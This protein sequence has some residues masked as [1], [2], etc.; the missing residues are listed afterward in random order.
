MTSALRIDRLTLSNFRCFEKFTVDLH[1][2][3]TVLVAENGQGKTA[4]LEAIRIALGLFVDTIA[5]TRQARVFSLSDVRTVRD[6]GDK[7]R[8]VF[9][10]EF[11]AEGDFDG[12]SIHW[13][14]ALNHSAV[15]PRTTTRKAEAL[16]QVAQHL[17]DQLE[18]YR[19]EGGD[20]V[21]ILPLVAFYGTNRLWRE[22]RLSGREIATG[23]TGITRT[24]GYSGCLS[25]SSSLRGIVEWYEVMMSEASGW[26]PFKVVPLLAGVERA[27]R[28]VLE[29]TGWGK[30]HWDRRELLVE[31]AEQGRLPLTS[32]SDGVRTMIALVMD[33]ARRC[34]SLNPHLSEDA[35]LKTPGV[36]LIDEVDMHL[37]PAW[38]Q[39]VVELLQEA[40]PALQMILTTHSPQVLSTVDAESI[41]MIRL[42]D[43]HATIRKPRFQTRGVES[44]DI[45]AK[46]MNVDPVPQVEQARWLN[47]YRA[48]MQTDEHESLDGKKLWIKLVEHF[49]EDHPVLSEIDT[50]RRLQ[51]FKQANKISPTTL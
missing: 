32:L 16:R 35:P 10:T 29:P 6:E 25:S 9:P 18:E 7:M 17:R 5:G 49:G 22:H 12:Q 11:A 50:L 42:I 2:D 28:V 23:L 36:L 31:H 48:M 34:V 38:Q 45:L 14:R 40:F 20:Q 33:I 8:E 30:L 46:I 26:V 13:S 15:R 37:H 47:D 39:R 41:R 4:V 24:S 27:M 19:N 43:G 1:P 44:A 51:Q 21:P 3:L